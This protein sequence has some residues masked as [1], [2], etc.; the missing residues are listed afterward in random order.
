MSEEVGG[1]WELGPDAFVRYGCYCGYAVDIDYDGF[2]FKL[3]CPSCGEDI[4][5]RELWDGERRIWRRE[6]HSGPGL[7]GLGMG[8]EYFVPQPHFTGEQLLGAIFDGIGPPEPE[9]DSEHP[10]PYCGQGG[11][12]KYDHTQS[13]EWYGKD[14]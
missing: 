4:P 14:L 8:L 12:N 11:R 7:R 2:V 9:A 6:T 1:D 3:E 10:C 13:C 5:V